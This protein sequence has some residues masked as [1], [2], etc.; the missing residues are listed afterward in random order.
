[1]PAGALADPQPVSSGSGFGGGH[2]RSFLGLELDGTV[3][4]RLDGPVLSSSWRPPPPTDSR[5]ARKRGAILEAATAALPAQRLP[6]HQHGRDRR[7][8]GGLEADRLQ[9]LRRQGATVHG[10]RRRR[11]RRGRRAARGRGAASSSRPTTWRPGCA[12]SPGGSSTSV[13]QPR[14]MQLRRLVIGEAGRFPE[15]GRAFYERGAG[16]RG[17]AAGRGL[18]PPRRPRG[19]R[20]RRPGARGGP[21]QLAGDVRAGEPGD[22]AGRR[23]VPSPAELD[24]YAESGV[25]AFLA[26]YGPRD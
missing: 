18:R 3:L 24:R 17:G 5:S 11:R 7:R 26:A 12:T 6:R 20:A 23:G 21:L 13:M 9:A 14:L 15:L 2:R 8:R 25:R 4:Y 22:A 16:R 19:A 10:D 1:M